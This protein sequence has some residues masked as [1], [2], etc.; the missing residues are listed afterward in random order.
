MSPTPPPATHRPST[1]PVVFDSHLL[2][3]LNAQVPTMNSYQSMDLPLPANPM[4]DETIMSRGTSRQSTPMAPLLPTPLVDFEAILQQTQPTAAQ[5][6][7]QPASKT[8]KAGAAKS[9]ATRKPREAKTSSDDLPTLEERM[10]NG[11]PIPRRRRDISS[12]AALISLAQAEEQTVIYRRT[13]TGELKR[14]VQE[15]THRYGSLLSKPPSHDLPA[16]AKVQYAYSQEFGVWYPV[17]LLCL[18]R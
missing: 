11:L 4:A 13:E 15:T 12:V 14:E 6:P 10:M 16:G 18:L 3:A 9:S 8:K 7:E 17:W 2:T 5:E 1:Q